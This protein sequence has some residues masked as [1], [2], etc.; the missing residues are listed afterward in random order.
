MPL[1]SESQESRGVT[2]QL[3]RGF[4]IGLGAIASLLVLLQLLV[5]QTGAN[6]SEYARLINLA[7]RQRMLSQ[8]ITKAALL[9]ERGLEASTTKLNESARQLDSAH[10]Q[11]TEA[12]PTADT[13]Q[14]LLK[15]EPLTRKLSEKALVWLENRDPTHLYAL[16][17]VEG[18]FLCSME[19]VVSAFEEDARGTIRKQER[20]QWLVVLA[21][22][23]LV[24][25]ESHWIFSPLVSR[26]DASVTALRLARGEA[27]QAQAQAEEAAAV[28]AQFL[29]NMSHEVRTPM[30]GILG[31][32]ELLVE[33]NLDPECHSYAK[34]V[35]GSAESLLR[36]LNDILDLSKLER[37][38]YRIERSAF[39]LVALA[40]SVVALYRPA[41]RDRN[42]GLK[43]EFESDTPRWVWGDPSRLRQILT[44][45]VDNALKFTQVGG[46]VLSIEPR[47]GNTVLFQ[48]SDTGPGIPPQQVE[49]IFN[50]F[51]QVD[52]SHSRTHQGTGL[53]LAIVQHLVK[54][55][56]GKLGVKS[57][58]GRGSTFWFE[59]EMAPAADV[60]EV[61]APSR[62]RFK[63]RVL[64]VEDNKINLLL[65]TRLLGDYKI[66]YETAEHGQQA[67]ERLAEGS[68]DLVLMDCQ[69][70]VLD[71]YTATRRLRS[72][73][74]RLPVVAIT[75]NALPHHQQMCFDAGMDDY[76]SKP[77]R[78]AELER[79]LARFLQSQP[80][81]EKDPATSS[82]GRGP[83]DETF[84]DSP[85]CAPVRGC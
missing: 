36:V 34:A 43:V 65:C 84:T 12:A 77:L 18:Q 31:M 27:L 5:T 74:Y 60:T 8:R 10:R 32:S 51:H 26:L 13:R 21:M 4:R 75:A 76:I 67:L 49:A 1:P 17:E 37:G 81:H 39:D 19:E 38:R 85:G 25:A 72:Q 9:V 53:G 46:V 14:L 41:S 42:L 48:V 66:E 70:P 50:A 7:G 54:L 61:P 15:L 82:E 45:L 71:G 68:F 58:P 59:I 28:K 80:D 83:D 56:A 78:R 22:L 29:A 44:N 33:A 6:R 3:E 20:L 35:H 16:L 57:E 11:L 69:M 79:V 62:P 73:G 40:E 64:V 24:L 63:G 52:A 30:N 2:G 47:P 55:M 23:G